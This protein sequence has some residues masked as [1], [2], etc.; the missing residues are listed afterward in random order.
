MIN[1][2]CKSGTAVFR[3]KRPMWGGRTGASP[4]DG[5]RVLS[6]CEIISITSIVY[7][8]G[9]A[10]VC[11]LISDWW[12]IAVLTYACMC[13]KCAS[14]FV[15]GM[16]DVCP[17]HFDYCTYCA[18][19]IRLGT[20]QDQISYFQLFEIWCRLYQLV[21]EEQIAFLH[22]HRLVFSIIKIR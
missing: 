14:C 9:Y 10:S 6:M 22:N 13:D 16:F 4:S 12:S 15:F 11:S 20:G 1:T 18:Y 8:Y 19:P 17:L 3:A 21:H 2:N 5:S 7:T